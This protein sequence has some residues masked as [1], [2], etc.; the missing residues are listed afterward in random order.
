MSDYFLSYLSMCVKFPPLMC[1]AMSPYLWRTLH[2]NR[3][4]G[5]TIQTKFRRFAPGGGEGVYI[6]NQIKPPKWTLSL[7]G[8]SICFPTFLFAGWGERGG[9]LIGGL[10]GR[11]FGSSTNHFC[12]HQHFSM[13]DRMILEQLAPH[14]C[15]GYP[16]CAKR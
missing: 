10:V 8:G 4:I 11:L 13:S 1:R 7:G 12:S 3:H 9:L 14:F 15:M 2:A 16:W 5:S 6:G